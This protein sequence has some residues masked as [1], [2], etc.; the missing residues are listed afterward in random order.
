MT[1]ELPQHLPLPTLSRVQASLEQ[2]KLLPEGGGAGMSVE[3]ISAITKLEGGMAPFR[4]GVD[5]GQG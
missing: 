5:F 1:D 3:S 4:E 2:V